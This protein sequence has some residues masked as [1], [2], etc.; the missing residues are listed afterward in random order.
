[1]NRRRYGEQRLSSL[2]AGLP[3][4]PDAITE[5]IARAVLDY[6]MG[7]ATDD[8]AIITFTAIAEGEVP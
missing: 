2:V 5:G 3:H 7:D 8:I 6:Q 4:Q 1:V